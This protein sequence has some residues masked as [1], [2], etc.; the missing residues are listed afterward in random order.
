MPIPS[1][2]DVG[3]GP[4]PALALLDTADSFIQLDALSAGDF[5]LERATVSSALLATADVGD[6]LTAAPL[7]TVPDPAPLVAPLVA[8]KFGAAV[9]QSDSTPA[10]VMAVVMASVVPSSEDH[11]AYPST[12][13]APGPTRAGDSAAPVPTGTGDSAASSPRQKRKHRKPKRVR[14]IGELGTA[15]PAA[16]PRQLGVFPRRWRGLM[17]KTGGGG[18][19]G[20]H[21]HFTALDTTLLLEHVCLPVTCYLL[22]VICYLLSVI[23]DLVVG[24]FRSHAWLAVVLRL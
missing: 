9:L 10:V 17:E 15:T 13:T 19:G 7:D 14:S 11:A 18:A 16:A 23:C 21:L 1:T 12:A 24:C 20:G 3:V 6:D 22:S 5:S 4:G 2:P 8:P